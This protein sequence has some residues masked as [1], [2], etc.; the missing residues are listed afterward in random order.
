[1]TTGI[2]CTSLRDL[3]TVQ[4]HPFLLALCVLLLRYHQAPRHGWSWHLALLR[5]L[6]YL[7]LQMFDA[8]AEAEVPL[9]VDAI[10]FIEEA[11]GVSL[12]RFVISLVVGVV[13][14]PDAGPQAW[15]VIRD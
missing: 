3:A 2:G 5:A 10:F 6:G 12:L 15:S 11:D 4:A 14:G 9:V 13:L 1:M 7:L 8:L